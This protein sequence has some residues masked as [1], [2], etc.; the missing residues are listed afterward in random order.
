MK[1]RRITFGWLDQAAALI[2]TAIE[3]NWTAEEL[4]RRMACV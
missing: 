4:D 3:Q 2:R 1:P